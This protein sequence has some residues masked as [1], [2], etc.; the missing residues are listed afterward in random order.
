M[1]FVAVGETPRGAYLRIMRLRILS[2]NVGRPRIIALMNGEPVFSG[3][4]KRAIA[5]DRLFV[6]KLNIEGDGQADL[7]VH[8]GFDKAV[9]AY[10]AGHWPWWESEHRLPCAPGT[11]GENLTLEH[12][13]ETE[14]CIGDRFTWGDVELEVAQPRAPCFKFLIHTQRQDAAALMTQS[15]R[16]GFYLRVVREGFAPAQ[17]A[18]LERVFASG[19]ANVRDA[20]FAVL[21]KPPVGQLQHVLA[22]PGLADSWR[23]AAQRRLDTRQG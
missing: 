23:S 1:R 11:F 18:Y 15:G 21:G 12:G 19:A 7:T 22:A 13:D 3:I 4:G 10:A 17:G 8:G 20:F 5:Q 2:V 16:C 6:S 14:V 9:Y